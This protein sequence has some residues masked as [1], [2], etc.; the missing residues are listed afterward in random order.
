MRDKTIIYA[1]R[2]LTYARLHNLNARRE[3]YF[4]AIRRLV[5]RDIAI[6]TELA[7]ILV[8]LYT[9]KRTSIT[10]PSVYVVP[11]L[12]ADAFLILVTRPLLTFPFFDSNLES[13]W[14]LL[15]IC[16]NIPVP[17]LLHTPDFLKHIQ[18]HRWYTHAT[19]FVLLFGF[20]NNKFYLDDIGP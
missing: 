2:S 1:R 19:R 13:K 6:T 4:Y 3:G 20:E 17:Q 9:S 18:A 12:Q 7:M 15:A 5:M 8:G 14:S 11:H 10:T 16:N